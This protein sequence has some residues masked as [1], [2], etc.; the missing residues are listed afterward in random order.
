MHEHP[1]YFVYSSFLISECARNPKKH[2][3][4]QLRG[5]SIRF[6]VSSRNNVSGI[7][8]SLLGKVK[9]R[10]ADGRTRSFFFVVSGS[11]TESCAAYSVNSRADRLQLESSDDNIV[12]NAQ[13][14][15][16]KNGTL[17]MDVSCTYRA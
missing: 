9:F 4:N 7:E 17:V 10:L 12:S 15:S 5:I 3:S 2:Q 8:V 14:C 6:V 16:V 13:F 1:R 11:V